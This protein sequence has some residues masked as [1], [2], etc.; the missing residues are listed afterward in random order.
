[1]QSLFDRWIKRRPTDHPRRWDAGFGGIPDSGIS[2]LFAQAAEHGAS[3][4]TNSWGSFPDRDPRFTP[5][6]IFSYRESITRDIDAYLHTDRSLVVL[7]AAGNSGADLDR[8]PGRIDSSSIGAEATSKNVIT[9]GASE[10]GRPDAKYPLHERVWED[11][12]YAAVPLAADNVANNPHGLAAFSS[13]GPTLP[14]GRIKP[15]VVAPGTTILSTRS[16]KISPPEHFSDFWGIS[17]DE[18]WCFSGGTSM[19]TP[20]VAGCCAVIRGAMMDTFRTKKAP[21]ATEV[22][23]VLINGAV[24]IKGQYAESEFKPPPNADYGFGRVDLRNSLLHV[25]PEVPGVAGY[26]TGPALSD[27]GVDDTRSWMHTIEVPK[28]GLG[29][30]GRPLTLKVTVAWADYPSPYLVNDLDMSVSDGGKTLWGNG[31]EEPDRINN[32]EQVVW[33]GV[34]P[35]KKYVVKVEAFSVPI[36]G[37]SQDFSYAW[38]IFE[39]ANSDSGTS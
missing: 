39:G 14:D 33:E 3:V 21:A 23:A 11:F 24:P 8:F 35:G 16:S 26:G 28:G 19:A 12:G 4:H 25:V 22:K 17:D 30:E 6:Q 18:K 5:E 1:M 13:R 32:V 37:H 20:L 15:D 34:E 7:F 29:H 38:R 36:D 27:D 2:T 9:V 31:G 10:N